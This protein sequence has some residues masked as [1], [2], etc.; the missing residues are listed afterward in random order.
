M[1]HT[2][3]R[4]WFNVKL[5]IYI[6]QYISYISSVYIYQYISYILNDKW[7]SSNFYILPKI[8][9][10]DE[11]KKAIAEQ[12]SPYVTLPAPTSLKGRPIVAGSS[13]PTKHLSELLDKILKPLV[14]KLKSYVQ[15]DWDF[16]SK[17][18]RQNDGDF[19]LL[20]CD[21]TSLYTIGYKNTEILYRPVLQ[22]VSSSKLPNLF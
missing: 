14:P 5:Y 10:C 17:I 6:Y 12:N 21:V 19:D 22:T 11:I 7:K 15:D 16:L 13:C 4:K 9:K 18:P 1:L 20:S 2:N 3:P 8:H